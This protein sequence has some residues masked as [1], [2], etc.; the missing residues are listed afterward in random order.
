MNEKIV[1]SISEARTE[2]RYSLTR[3]RVTDKTF[4]GQLMIYHLTEP[5]P[6]DINATERSKQTLKDF[7]TDLIKT[8]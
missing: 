7:L 1:V 3:T 2:V 8:M 6:D 4:R 5:I